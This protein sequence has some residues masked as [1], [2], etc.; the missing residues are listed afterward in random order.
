MLRLR[1]VFES[2]TSLVVS[3]LSLIKLIRELVVGIISYFRGFTA[4]SCL[5]HDATSFLA[6]LCFDRALWT[7]ELTLETGRCGTFTVMGSRFSLIL[8]FIKLL[9]SWDFDVK[10]PAYAFQEV[11]G[12]CIS[13]VTYRLLLAFILLIPGSRVE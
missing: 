2:D 3:G 9:E 6:K 10:V 8:A 11:I 1:Y 12:N 7:L 5:S 4:D 13:F